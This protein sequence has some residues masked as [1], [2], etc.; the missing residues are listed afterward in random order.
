MLDG[1]R[2]EFP[3]VLTLARRVPHPRVARAPILWSVMAAFGA[4]FFVSALVTILFSILFRSIPS[5]APLPAPFEI[6]RL[7]ATAAALAVAWIAGGRGAVAAYVGILIVESLLGLPSRQRFCGVIGV[8][9]AFAGDYCSAVRYLI[10]FWP[11]TLG[12]A[13]AFALVRWLRGLPGDRNP[14]LEAA[15]VFTLVQIVA[16]SL[17]SAGL[18]PVGI[19]SPEGPLIGLAVAI[20]AGVAMGYAILRRALRRWRTLGIIALVVGAE[21]VLL[22]LP[23]FVSQVLQV[24]GTNLI[25]PFDLLAL[26]S[27]V[28]AIGAATIV[29]YSAAARRGSATESA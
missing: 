9:P 12:A 26:F 19:G 7:I 2:R 6:A 17:L 3:E 16:G 11:Q 13:L 23:T 8:D 27:P 18:G 28:F 14:T 25:G 22:S 21:Y 15:G 29:L 4:G 5:G 10:G 1:L 24:P 20:G